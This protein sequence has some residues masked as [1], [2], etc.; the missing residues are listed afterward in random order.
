MVFFPNQTFYGSRY[1]D[2]KSLNVI[3]SSGGSARFSEIE[4]TSSKC[5]SEGDVSILREMESPEHL[6]RQNGSLKG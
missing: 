3:G 6:L 1:P 2:R 5:F 4:K